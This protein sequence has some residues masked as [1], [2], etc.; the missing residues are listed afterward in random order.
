MVLSFGSFILHKLYTFWCHVEC[1]REL[2]QHWSWVHHRK[3]G[4]SALYVPTNVSNFLLLFSCSGELLV[5]IFYKS[6]LQ[7]TSCI[8]LVWD[9]LMGWA[10]ASPTPVKW[11]VDLLNLLPVCLSMLWSWNH[12]PVYQQPRCV[13][14]MMR[15]HSTI[16]LQELFMHLSIAAKDY[17]TW[18]TQSYLFKF[19]DPFE[20]GDAN[21][22]CWSNV[23][24]DLKGAWTC[25]T[26]CRGWQDFPASLVVRVFKRFVVC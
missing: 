25:V 10:W 13:E 5:S 4:S 16:C 20:Q 9:T 15:K 1:Y 26:E 8:N 17:G 12:S 7:F 19:T 6:T 11:I 2:Q 3:E 22:W 14:T 21:C 23:C 24:S 18:M